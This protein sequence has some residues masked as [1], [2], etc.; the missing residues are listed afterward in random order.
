MEL[1]FESA[2]AYTRHPD[3]WAE[4]PPVVGQIHLG[5]VSG[6]PITGEDILRLDAYCRAR[7]IE[8]V[9]NQNSFG[10]LTRW[11]LL[12]R[13][14]HL[15]ECPDGFDWP[16]PGS[17]HADF[18]WSLD[19]TD[20][21]SIAF[22]AD[23]Y[24]ELLPHFTSKKFNVGCDETHDLGQGKNKEECQR[25]GKAQVYL[26]FLLNIHEL[27]KQRGRRM[28]I[29]ADAFFEHPELL[30]KLPKDVVLLEWGYGIGHPYDA[31]GARYAEAGL[32]FYVCP[33]TSTFGSIAGRHYRG[34]NNIINAA[35][36]GHKHG[37]AGF[38][39]TDWGGGGHIQYLP[40]SY[41]GYLAGAAASWCN[42]TYS[43]EDLVGALDL[44]VFCDSA[45]VMGKIAYELGNVYLNF[46]KEN[47]PMFDLLWQE[48]DK[49]PPEQ[50]EEKKLIAA[51]EQ[52]S[53]IMEPLGKASMDRADAALVQAEFANAAKYMQYSCQYGLAKHQKT[54][55]SAQTRKA[56]ANN[57]RDAL[58]EHH[59]LWFA[60]NRKG[61]LDDACYPTEQQLIKLANLK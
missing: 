11:L 29:W 18:P 23:L 17:G 8:L 47:N 15:A 34:L 50:A 2:F 38:L 12:P 10:H 19:P 41:V 32:D 33:S 4:C 60:R 57:L 25:K 40:V 27:V 48:L 56:L 5:S 6:T 3:A 28:H 51:Q 54:I 16:W 22:L 55:N 21:K 35:V 7:F 61:G 37:A 36:N 52:I 31:S 58:A 14:N 1:Y 42:K 26:E 9:P 20:P 39:N 43:E 24:D 45:K 53:S 49:A 44:H 13:Y 30:A 46:D 59:R